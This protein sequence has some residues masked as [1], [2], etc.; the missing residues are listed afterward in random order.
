MVLRVAVRG[1]ILVIHP[2]IKKTINRITHTF[3]SY[4]LPGEIKRLRGL[5]K[6]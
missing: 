2:Q 5:M 3:M 6:G 1:F 4:N